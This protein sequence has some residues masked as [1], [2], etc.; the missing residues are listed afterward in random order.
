MY[1]FWLNCQQIV[2][3]VP[4]SLHMQPF[5]SNG[6]VRDIHLSNMSAQWRREWFSILLRQPSFS[7]VILSDNQF[8]EYRTRPI[9]VR[10]LQ[11]VHWHV[12]YL[13]FHVNPV[14]TTRGYAVYRWPQNIVAARSVQHASAR[15]VEFPSCQ[16]LGGFPQ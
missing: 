2:G 3:R 13:G 11:I 15:E 7:L 12:L 5:T 1:F 6:I 14:G 4:V 16:D 9:V 8:G 10:T